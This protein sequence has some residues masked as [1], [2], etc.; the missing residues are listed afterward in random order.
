MTYQKNYSFYRK[1]MA[2]NLASKHI[3]FGTALSC[4]R[5]RAPTTI[6]E[7]VKLNWN[8]ESD[9]PEIPMSYP[10]IRPLEAATMHVITTEAVILPWNPVPVPGPSTAK[11]PTAILFL[12][13]LP[14]PP[15]TQIYRN[16]IKRDKEV[17]RSLVESTNLKQNKLLG[18]RLL[19]IDKHTKSLFPSV[20]PKR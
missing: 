5:N 1:Q 17:E 16:W 12:I 19:A 4:N 7:S 2:K 15:E 18:L 6:L 20:P 10:N 11:A 14:P 13:F 8:R 9:I 3:H